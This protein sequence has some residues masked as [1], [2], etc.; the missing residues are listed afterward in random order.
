MLNFCNRECNSFLSGEIVAS[1]CGKMNFVKWTCWEFLN[2]N[3]YPPGVITSTY[4]DKASVWHDL[5]YTGRRGTICLGGVTC[6]RRSDGLSV[7]LPSLGRWMNRNGL[8]DLEEE[9][10]ADGFVADGGLGFSFSGSCTDWP[11]ICQFI[12]R[13]KHR[14][15]FYDEKPTRHKSH[16]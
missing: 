3:F 8:G 6:L 7:K 5:D 1:N 16:S 10:F 9:F 2:S 12:R 14:S 15:V 11:E 4:T 13:I